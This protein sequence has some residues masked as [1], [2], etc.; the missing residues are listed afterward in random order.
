[1]HRHKTGALIRASVRLGALCCADI[2]T[3]QLAQLD[4]YAACIGLAFQVRD[5]IL[6]VEADTETLGKTQ[7]ADM[8]LNKPTYPSL[9]GLTAARQ[10]AD[11]L[12]Q[13]AIAELADFDA[14]ANG[15]RGLSAFI[16]SR[17]H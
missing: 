3:R 14:R 2:N 13:R 9:L 10:K 8:A 12:H 5:D 4:A 11:E 1:M 15:L 7:G 6:D 17:P 16:V